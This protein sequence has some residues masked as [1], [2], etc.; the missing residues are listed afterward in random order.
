M[1]VEDAK[2]QASDRK[3]TMTYSQNVNSDLKCSY[4]CGET[5]ARGTQLNSRLISADCTAGQETQNLHSLI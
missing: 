1:D 5:L 3:E 4:F 2:V